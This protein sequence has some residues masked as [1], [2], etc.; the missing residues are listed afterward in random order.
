MYGCYQYIT[1]SFFQ[2]QIVS[3]KGTQIPKGLLEI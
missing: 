1:F 2:K 3:F